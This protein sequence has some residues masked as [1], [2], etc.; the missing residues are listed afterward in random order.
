MT[1]SRARISRCSVLFADEVQLRFKSRGRAGDQSPSTSLIERPRHQ[2]AG[3]TSL[4][5]AS[6]GDCEAVGMIS[7]PFE[8]SVNRGRLLMTNKFG[9]RPAQ[10]LLRHTSPPLPRSFTRTKQVAAIRMPEGGIVT[11][12][13]RSPVGRGDGGPLQPRPPRDGDSV[14]K[15]GWK[16]GGL[17]PFFTS[18][19]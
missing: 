8:W 17:T 11:V 9:I 3:Q 12:G 5:K 15:Q 4:E 19:N 16:G 10:R 14:S 13:T 6:G 7:P 1:T 18:H 2:E